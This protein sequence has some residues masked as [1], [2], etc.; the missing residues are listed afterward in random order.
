MLPHKNVSS[1]AR[2]EDYSLGRDAV[3]RELPKIPDSADSRKI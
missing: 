2:V 1:I 3:K